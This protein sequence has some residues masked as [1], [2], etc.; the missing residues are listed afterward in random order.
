MKK[1]TKLKSQK[2]IAKKYNQTETYLRYLEIGN[3]S[4]VTIWQGI[5]QD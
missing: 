3:T 4:N 2:K 5:E 1:L